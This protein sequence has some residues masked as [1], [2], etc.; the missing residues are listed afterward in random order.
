M[1]RLRHCDVCNDWH[2]LE[3]WPQACMGHYRK[4]KSGKSSQVM[5]DID[6]YKSMITGEIIQ[7]RRQHRD[8]LK[9]HGKI[10]VGNEHE[11]AMKRERKEMSPVEQTVKRA[12]DAHEQGYRS[13]PMSREEFDR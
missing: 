10:E 4:D 5:G 7:G 9:A 2:E 6:P 8:H 12:M 11:A 3:E 13:R 1:A